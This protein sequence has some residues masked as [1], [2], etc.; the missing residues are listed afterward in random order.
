M[1]AHPPAPAS[2][3]DH[4][5]IVHDLKELALF[6]FHWSRGCHDSQSMGWS[7]SEYAP[8][9][10]VLCVSAPIM[11]PSFSGPAKVRPAQSGHGIYIEGHFLSTS[12][13]WHESGFP[14]TEN[15]LYTVIEANW[16]DMTGHVHQGGVPKARAQLDA[17]VRFSFSERR[18]CWP[19][20]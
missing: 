18:S 3:P 19:D 6:I 2:I 20:P 9:V 16:H 4:V 8:Q 17:P 15:D 12:G 5:H 7:A 13:V 11:S 1:M 14:S 10:L